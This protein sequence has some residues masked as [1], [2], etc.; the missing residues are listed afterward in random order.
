MVFRLVRS[1]LVGIGLAVFAGIIYLAGLWVYLRY[2]LVPAHH[3]IG[4]VSVDSVELGPSLLIIFVIFLGGF[5]WDW[6]RSRG[7]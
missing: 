1:A 3:E 4:T 5:A 6:R 7:R 2:V